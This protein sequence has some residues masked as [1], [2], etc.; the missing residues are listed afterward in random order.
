MTQADSIAQK[1]AG[2]F[3][4]QAL[5]T[6]FPALGR[7]GAGIFFDNAAGAQ[8]PQRVLDAVT[9]HLL[10]HNVQ[11]GGRYPQS[12]AVDAAIQSAR[13]KVAAFLNA[14]RPEE[15]AFG[16]NAT[17]FIRLVS[18]AI[19]QTLGARSEIIVTD[20]DHE[21]NVATWLALERAGAHFQWWRMRD[22]GRLHCA[23]L[24]PLLG[25]RTRLLACT[26]AS[27]ALGSLVDVRRA[28]ELVHSAGGELFLDSVHYAPHGPIDVQ[29]IGC[30]Y[31]VC[32][33]YKIFA[34]HMGFLWG[35][36]ESLAALPT[37][38]EDFIPDRPPG[39][40]E[41]GT[42]IYENVAGMAAAVDY[43][44]DLGRGLAVT[45]EVGEARS[46]RENCRA[47]MNGIR[48]YEQGLSLELIRVLRD[49]GATI[50][51]VSAEEE[52]AQRVPTVSFTLSGIAPAAV[53]E[54]AARAGIGVRDGHMYSPRLMKRLGLALEA[55]AVR[56][57]L[58]H[59][60]THAEIHRFGDVVARLRPSRR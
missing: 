18:L 15:I 46:L 16:M 4:A 30:D 56:A 17:S 36:Y 20:L 40:I 35:R 57:S 33:G 38:R 1:R 8:V 37:F 12:I 59:Y 26:A 53:T 47:A 39:K 14:R 29:A 45:D 6:Q 60:N 31:L 49:A 5:R 22:D 28:A 11:R 9:A 48:A 58:A 25:P 7:P 23:D 10:N 43:L 51:G 13:E 3:P 41:A 52:L 2:E 34:P 44:G 32:S 50:Y 27:N 54:A 24:E 21:A 19:G 42:F 55:G